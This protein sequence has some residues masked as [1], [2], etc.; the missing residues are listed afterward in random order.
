MPIRDHTETGPGR[1]RGA[2][3]VSEAEPGDRP[4]FTRS[5]VAFNAITF[6]SFCNIAIFFQ[7]HDY[8]GTLPMDPR[9]FGFLIAIFSL[10]VLVVRPFIS[11][12]LDEGNARKWLLIST[13]AV[14]VSLFLY[15]W[16]RT[17]ETMTLVRLAHGAGYVVMNTALVALLVG[18]I[19]PGRSGQAFGLFS[20]IT[21]LPYALIPPILAPVMA[22]AGGFGRVLDLSALFMALTFPLV[23]LLD[24]VVAGKAK[25]ETSGPW[26]RAILENL[27]DP[28]ILL[29]LF[30]S[31]VVWTT[32][33]PVFFFLESYGDKLGISNAGW[34]FTLSTFAE[35]G[36]RVVAGKAF[37]RYDKQ[38]VL[39]AAVAWLGVGFL[40]LGGVSSNPAFFLV[41]IFLGLGWGVVMPL[42][43]AIVFDISQPRFRALNT[44][45][46]MVVFQGGF[47]LGPLLGGAVLL[48]WGHGVLYS[49]SGV[50]LL[51]TTALLV[52]IKRRRTRL[53]DPAHDQ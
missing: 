53:P 33:A 6:L 30:I 22:W 41:G 1:G 49:A 8:L 35:I 43:T 44:N 28:R 40:L 25:P 38:R 14:I 12:F 10:V 2:G 27:R 32:F 5:F 3:D 36:V 24:P 51:M 46:A 4:L 37:D 7:F 50:I 18:Y 45:L 47:F 19:P 29:L 15:D 42:L 9:W 48:H 23:L 20:I 52:L 26:A 39:G 17:V 16:A 21:L 34:F 13:G 31:L 11:P